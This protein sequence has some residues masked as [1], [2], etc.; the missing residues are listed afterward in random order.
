M[1][2]CHI[3]ELGT[4]LAQTPKGTL[5]TSVSI[6][7][8]TV[9]NKTHSCGTDIG[10]TF[11]FISE[12]CRSDSNCGFDNLEAT[13]DVAV[14][15]CESQLRVTA[16]GYEDGRTCQSLSLFQDDASGESICILADLVL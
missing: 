10:N 7:L 6:S 5:R 12:Q 4:D 8:L 16:G 1:R 15:I 9:E 11:Y 3:R 13:E 2:G 14:C